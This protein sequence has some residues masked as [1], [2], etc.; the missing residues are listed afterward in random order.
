MPTKEQIEKTAR[1][2]ALMTKDFFEIEMPRLKTFASIA[3]EYGVK[4][5]RVQRYAKKVGFEYTPFGRGKCNDDFFSVDTMEAFYVA[6]FIAGDGNLSSVRLKDPHIKHRTDDGGKSISIK[7]A[8]KDRNFVSKIRD[9]LGIENPIFDDVSTE[10]LLPDSRYKSASY[11]SS[12]YCTSPQ[13]FDDLARFNIT[14]NKSLTLEFPEWMKSHPLRH[15]FIRGYYDADGCWSFRYNKDKNKQ[16]TK[17]RQIR[18]SVRGTKNFLTD[19]R[20]ILET[21]LTI[22]KKTGD[23]PLSGGI[24]KL[25]YAGNQ[26]TKK[27]SDYLYKD[28]TLYLERKH[29]IATSHGK[30]A[31]MT[32]TESVIQYLID[33]SL[34]FPTR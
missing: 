26:I 10:H 27:I 13:M 8:S 21:D 15:H 5:L 4:P 33:N 1:F 19:I 20:S 3:R 32:P 28:A 11:G 23:I 9:I 30:A 17:D 16:D 25:E 22:R 14:P 34:P 6:G 18:C 24:H 29:L 12:I 31:P 7:L 2:S